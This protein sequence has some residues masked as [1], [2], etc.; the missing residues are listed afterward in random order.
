MTA[1]V[2]FTAEESNPTLP[3]AD[4]PYTVADQDLGNPPLQEALLDPVELPWLWLLAVMGERAFPGSNRTLHYQPRGTDTLSIGDP[5][6]WI[7]ERHRTSLMQ[8]SLRPGVVQSLVFD[9]GT[10]MHVWQGE[11]F[12]EIQGWQRLDMLYTMRNEPSVQ[13]FLSAY[14]V[15]IKVLNE[16][17]PHIRK[18]FGPE[19]LVSLEIVR[20]PEM[21]GHQELFAYIRTALPVDEALDQLDKL[22]E[23]WFLDQL[24]SVGGLF[25]FNLEFA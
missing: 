15:L 20:D 11:C 22:D 7:E 2:V 12:G 1:G 17:V 3:P 24:D 14:P 8:R 9:Y 16:A 5:R 6:C 13:H 18:Y 23:A 25:N 21:I 19:P 4:R 10:S